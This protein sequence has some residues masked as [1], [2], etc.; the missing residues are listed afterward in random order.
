MPVGRQRPTAH[1]DEW[2]HSRVTF[3]CV[4]RTAAMCHNL[5][6][7]A[8]VVVGQQGRLVIPAAVRA[9]LDLKPGDHLHLLVADGRLIL[10]RPAD[11]VSELRGLAT[12][13]P[14]GRS[15]VAE[16]L[17]ERRAAAAVE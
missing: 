5:R 9:A 3:I 14:R 11:A 8:T 12:P 15:L 2:A 17:A 7:R 6:V 10:E 13:V 4:A 16:L 1:G